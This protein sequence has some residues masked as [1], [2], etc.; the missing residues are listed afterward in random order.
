MNNKIKKRGFSV[1]ILFMLMIA[2]LVIRL[3]DIQLIN[4]ESF[5]SNDVNLIKSSVSQRTQEIVIDQGRGRFIDRHSN[6]L[7]HEYYPSL[8]LFPFLKNID[9]PVEQ[10][11][12]I[13]DIPSYQITSSLKEA[14][15]PVVFGDEK[16]LSLTE[17]QMNKINELEIPGVFAVYRQ[18]ALDGEIAQ[19]LLGIIRENEKL[20]S[21]RYPEKTYLSSRTKVGITGLQAAFDEF[22]LPEGEA[23]LLYHVAGD[24][25]PLFGIDVKYTAPANPFYPVAIKTTIDREM[26]ELAEDLVIKHGI[27]KGGVVLL[28]IKS[29]DILAM[30]SAPTINPSD[31]FGDGSADN[32]ML[33]PHFPGSVFKTVTA[34]AV[35]ENNIDVSERTFNCDLD[36]YGEPNPVYELGELN[37]TESF[38]K[39]CNYTFTKLAE[40][41]IEKNPDVI[42]E[43]SN[44][45]GIINPVGWHGDVFR[46]NDFKQ[47]SGEY[48]GTIWGD[49]K[50]KSSSK[51][52]AQISVGQKDVRITPLAIANMMATIARGGEKK[53]TRAVSDVL[54]KNGSTLFSF[55]E[56]KVKDEDTISPYTAMKLQELL[57]EVVESGTGMKFKSLPYK[58]AGKSGT[59]ELG[60]KN[61]EEALVNKWFAGYFPMEDPKYAM[62]VVELGQVSSKSPTNEVYF[63]MVNGIYK[64]DLSRNEAL[65]ES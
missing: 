18:Y 35:I 58:V 49:E 6:A 9:W 40:E 54:Y 44:K 37:F 3:I 60:K 47:M 28:D 51:A 52:I 38:A 4:T 15:E 10:V 65:K 45:L 8:V 59:A 2:G 17:T 20:L 34:A 30:V 33:L 32:Q 22:L 29:S 42:E 27:K 12:E 23:K 56:Q 11:A 24:G 26:Q 55:P 57:A 25:N 64:I 7:T 41:M 50:D 46:L 36:L 61:N 5:S 13:I 63:D 39:S 48:E 62:V 31:P 16:P 1:L 43:F 53:Q 21:K 14:K 19:H